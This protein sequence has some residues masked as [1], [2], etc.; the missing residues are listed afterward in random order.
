MNVNK[1]CTDKLI[2]IVMKGGKRIQKVTSRP[3]KVLKHL[4]DYLGIIQ[5]ASLVR[6]STLTDDDTRA[7][8]YIK[9]IFVKTANIF[10]L[11]FPQLIQNNQSMKERNPR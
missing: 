8:G 3:V 6:T 2:I 9:N 10:T 4:S 1:S 5:N 7:V 11:V